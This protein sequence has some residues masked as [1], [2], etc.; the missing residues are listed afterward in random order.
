MGIDAVLGRPL[1]EATVT[2]STILGGQTMRAYLADYSSLGTGEK[3]W[4]EPPGALIDA[5]DVADLESEAD[6]EYEL[7]GAHENEQ[8]AHEGISPDG[9]TVVD[10][11]RTRRTRERFVA[12]LRPGQAARGIVRVDG[13]RGTRIAVRV[14]G[15]PAS[16]IVLG[17]DEDWTECTFDVPAHLAGERA[18]VELV[19]DA[20][21]V[22]TF[23]YWF[24]ALTPG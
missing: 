7:L 23:H 8:V 5:L 9:A 14:G 21:S 10:G 18:R 17:D 1:H 15:E 2:D 24:Y 4:T 12:H 22:T 13:P 6:H 11:G 19:V 16:Q 20:G 3:P